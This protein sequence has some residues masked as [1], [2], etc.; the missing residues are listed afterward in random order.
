MDNA[1]IAKMMLRTA[2]TDVFMGKGRVI[3]HEFFREYTGNPK[4]TI[5]DLIK[6]WQETYPDLAITQKMNVL[7]I[8]FEV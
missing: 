1:T 7:I 3:P 5:D 4:P 2:K 6:A 8:N